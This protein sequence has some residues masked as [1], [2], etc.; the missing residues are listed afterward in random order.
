MGSLP[1]GFHL[2][3][4]PFLLSL[5]LLPLVAGRTEP[6]PGL[7]VGALTCASLVWR[8]LSPGLPRPAFPR[9]FGWV[10]AFLALATA[11]FPLS[12]N[13]GASW[14][15]LLWYGCCAVAAWLAGDLT[16]RGGVNRL[17]AAVLGGGVIAAGLGVQEHVVHL[18]ADDLSW[19]S[20]SLFDN[21]NFFAGFVIP[22]T[23]FAFTLA[24]QRPESFRPLTWGA[25]VVLVGLTLGGGFTSTGSRGGLVSLAAGLGAVLLLALWRGL[26]RRRENLA[27][28]AVLLAALAAGGAA[29]SSPL[30]GRQVVGQGAPLPED[31]C[32]RGAIVATAQSNRFRILTWKGTWNMARKR[33][34]L[35]WGAGSYETA[36]APHAV[37]GF[38]RHA[39]QSYLQLA[40]EGGFAA[41]LVWLVLLGLALTTVL[42][43]SDAP[44]PWMVPAGA[45]L[46]AT[47][48]HNLID[49]LLFVPAIGTLTWVM[50]GM[51]LTPAPSDPALVEP[52]PAASEPETPGNARG[53]KVR[54]APPRGPKPA[55]R[56]VA[57]CRLHPR[58][59][60]VAGCAGMVA[61][62]CGV[63]AHGRAE[64]DRGKVT[65]S[66]SPAAG[67]ARL[68]AAAALLPLD[69]QV[70][71]ARA[72]LLWR[73]QRSEDALREAE[74]ALRLA[75]F[76]PPA[77]KT[78]G[79]FQERTNRV[80]EAEATYRAG[81]A[82]APSET[83]LLIALAEL[84]YTQGRREESLE[85][86]RRVLAVE[87][88]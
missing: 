30:L 55:T 43:R 72:A 54:R 84:L 37:A 3:E 20:F 64:L 82:L 80:A 23:T 7:A 78:L 28:A 26:H 65:G 56:A 81:L 25:T 58:A 34:V 41:P 60:G 4:I 27:W 9:A 8:L 32:G 36:F 47:G 77:Y 70:A 69:Q 46:A 44:P 85:Q 15:R 49:S 6:G 71:T 17:V 57:Q 83:V 87:D 1:A 10:V 31:L 13:Q 52:E 39:H 16:R 68:D 14:L 48:V 73:L 74:R 59:L 35:G 42:R 38:T 11:T 12:V 62:A 75:R 24:F 79:T 67:L 86:Y 29:C 40:A 21:P 66:A 51:L 88:S 45:T 53:R 33:P 2:S 63:A 76:R 22:C 61:L 5:F 18:K 19:R 50:V